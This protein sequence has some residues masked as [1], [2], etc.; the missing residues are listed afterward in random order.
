MS[1]TARVVHL[2]LHEHRNTKPCFFPHPQPPYSRQTTEHTSVKL[3]CQLI[4][5]SSVTAAPVRLQSV[6]IMTSG[7]SKQPIII[8]IKPQTAQGGSESTATSKSL[9]SHSKNKTTHCLFN[10]GVIT[11]GEYHPRG[12]QPR[13][14]HSCFNSLK[15]EL[16]ANWMLHGSS[17]TCR[18]KNVSQRVNLDKN[19]V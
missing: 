8:E 12:E 11:S 6:D 18:V 16:A 1:C 9:V 14:V 17:G 7:S 4:A 10:Q 5:T 2:C 13:C 19:L 15:I 3:R